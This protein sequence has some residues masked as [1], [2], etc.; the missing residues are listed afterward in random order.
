MDNLGFVLSQVAHIERKVYKH[1]YPSIRYPQ[2]VPVDTSAWPWAPTITH[3]ST[4][5]TGKARPVAARGDDFPIVKR[6]H[7]KHDVSVEMD[8]IAFEYS[9]EEVE[10][11]R[12]LNIP[13]QSEYA[14]E[15]RFLAERR[16]DEYVVDGFDDYGWDS[17]FKSSKVP[18]ETA[19]ANGALSSTKWK[20][21]S[22]ENIIADV[23][24][25]LENLYISSNT[26]ETAD[27]LLVPPNI[28]ANLSS[29]FISGTAVSVIEAIRANNLYT[30]RTGQPLLIREARG[31]ENAAAGNTGRA[32]AYY[33]D[34]MVLRLHLPMPFRFLPTE[35]Y[36]M[37]Y[38]T[39]GI[40]RCGGLEIRLPNAMR[41]L[42]GITD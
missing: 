25:L 38:M 10:Q 7:F 32:I 4:N 18:K 42:D 37:K 20:D 36:V 31:L 34:P 3:F 21:K 24:N 35:K 6:Q 26:V 22:P 40:F 28:W 19:A 27:T 14:M 41:Y 13:L 30:A 15:C 29:K 23:N 33:R 16:I 8:G 9:M 1:R 11:A 2:L 5:F 12:M 39:P 17:L